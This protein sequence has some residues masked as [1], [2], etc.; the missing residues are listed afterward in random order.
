MGVCEELPVAAT[1][2]MLLAFMQRDGDA[3]SHAE[4]LGSRMLASGAYMQS[5]TLGGEQ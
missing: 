3:A 5:Q 4:D 2:R 1:F